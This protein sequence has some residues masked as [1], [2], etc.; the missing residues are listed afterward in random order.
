MVEGMEGLEAP[1]GA[2]SALQSAIDA[3]KTAVAGL[4]EA[5]ATEQTPAPMVGKEPDELAPV[6]EDETGMEGE[7]TPDEATAA[8][9][10]ETAAPCACG[11][12]PCTC[13]SKKAFGTKPKG[14]LRT[15]LGI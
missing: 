14:D 11:K 8:P 6:T 2:T 12:K 10:G 4:E 13:G 15:A 7:G 1:E 9:G 5:I 3:V